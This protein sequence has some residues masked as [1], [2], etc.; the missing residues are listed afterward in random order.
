MFRV[1][2]DM[3][4]VSATREHVVSVIESINQPQVG[5][6]GYT[7]QVSEASVVGVR[8]SSGAFSVYIH[9]HLTETNEIVVYTHE[10]GELDI[11]GYPEVEQLALE[12][13]E[14]MG[15]I[16]DDLNF[17]NLSPV[18]QDEFMGR[19]RCFKPTE[20]GEKQADSEGGADG[21]QAESEEEIVGE[22]I[23]SETSVEEAAVEEAAESTVVGEDETDALVRGLL[24]EIKE[25]EVKRSNEVSSPA[26]GRNQDRDGEGVDRQETVCPETA[27]R[28]ARILVS[29]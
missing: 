10:D 3:T 18:Q 22:E 19:L 5:V 29:F 24:L 26:P 27:A 21:W 4:H 17:R 16:M 2:P 11:E 1:D 20:G 28:I 13:V 8:R 9:L 25:V 7:A 14:S 12:F 15:F 6:P 23:V